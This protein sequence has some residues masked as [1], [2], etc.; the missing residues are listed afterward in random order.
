MRTVLA[1]FALISFGC[2][3]AD[4][5]VCE[6]VSANKQALEVGVAHVAGD[7]QPP[8]STLPFLEAGASDVRRLGLSTIKAYLTPDYRTKYPQT[9]W[10]DVKSLVELAQTQQLRAVIDGF[11]TVI[12][13]TY[14]F[15][16]GVG[17]PWRT[18]DDDTLY[19]NET[20]EFQALTEHLLRTYAGTGKTFILQN[21][22]GDW[23]LHAETPL[24]REVDP[25]RIARMRRWLEA[26]QRGV[27]NARALIAS[28]GVEVRH[29]AE[30]NLTVTP[31]ASTVVD[32][33]LPGLCVD[34]V[35]YSAWDALALDVSKPLADQ[36]ATL[37]ATLTRAIARIRA[38]AG[39]VSVYL[40]EVGFAENEHP[41]GHAAALLEETVRTS[42]ELQL[43]HAI[44]WQV[45]DNECDGSA[46]RGLWLVRPDGAWSE[47]GDALRT[48]GGIVR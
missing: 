30:V 14:S 20:A 1:L 2:G 43:T 10:P 15:S 4:P 31:A 40:G 28:H 26:R 41:A 37:K 23:A 33:V 13:T 47:V 6:R 9:D 46:C 22:E 17:D 19:E 21:W 12:L 25:A 42:A 35:S 44:Y 38:A 16:N 45:Y 27:A 5:Q 34:A 8:T 18:R 36:R 7:Y 11:D 39:D 24:D 29:A 3:V 48:G 32:D